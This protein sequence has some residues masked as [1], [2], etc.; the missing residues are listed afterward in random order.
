MPGPM[1]VV[2]TTSSFGAASSR[3]LEL[4]R[5]SGLDLVPNPFGRTLTEDEAVELIQAHLPVGLL[6]GTGPVG[7]KALEVGRPHLKVVSRIGV[8][9]DN[10]DREL[11]DSMGVRV[12]RTPEAPTGSVVELTVGLLLDL[13]RRISAHDRR[14]RSGVWK[15][16]L[17]SSVEGK[18][19]GICGCGRIG[20]G[21]ALVMKA[22]GCEVQAYDPY[23]DREWHAEHGVDLVPDVATLF[24]TSDLVSIHAEYS[25]N[26]EGFVNEDLLRRSRPGLLLVNTARGKM[27]QESALVAALSD[28]TVGGAALDVFEEEPY[29]GPLAAFDNVILTPHIGSHTRESRIRM[30]TEAVL[31][32]ISGL[33]I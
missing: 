11:A 30:E 14:L 16:E 29:T 13:S 27:V 8:G 9:W 26:L 2:A 15:R 1:K 7:R 18:S 6:A 10:V 21:V 31:N 33:G 5:E 22:L 25:P 24:A 23:P 4:L 3:P 12:F 28:G 32:L 20:K 17:T 19:L